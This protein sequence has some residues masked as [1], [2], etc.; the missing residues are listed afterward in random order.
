MIN[1]LKTL[2][3]YTKYYLKCSTIGNVYVNYKDSRRDLKLYEKEYLDLKNH[4]YHV[5]ENY[6]TSE[7]ASKILAEFRCNLNKYSSFIS[8]SD[9]KRLF[10]VEQCSNWVRTFCNNE[11]L[12]AI[13]DLINKEKSRC[14][15][16]LGGFLKA[17]AHGSSGGGWHRDAFLSQ[18]KAMLYL[19]DVSEDNGPFQII[20]QSHHL[21]NV[22]CAIKKAKLS[23]WQNRITDEEVRNVEIALDL[24]RKTLIGKAGTLILFNST[25]IHRGMPIKSGERLSLTNYYFP[26]SRTISSLREQ[27]SPVLDENNISFH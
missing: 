7:L 9:D 2:Y 13:S 17:G 16:T 3:C 12:S 11:K 10:G 18:F 25:T 22:L 26:Y 19:S 27:F 15:F 23:H 14:A 1:L 6:I 24:K 8:E 20:P 5:I 21:K 4:G